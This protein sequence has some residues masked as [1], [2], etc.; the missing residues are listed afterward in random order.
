MT[1]PS[2]LKCGMERRVGGR[3]GT[4]ELCLPSCL[5]LAPPLPHFRCLSVCR[6]QGFGGQGQAC[7]PAAAQTSPATPRSGSAQG[8]GLSGPGVNLPRSVTC[9]LTYLISISLNRKSIILIFEYNFTTFY[10]KKLKD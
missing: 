8:Q 4:D 10:K 7:D 9:A 3:M 1:E 2:D 5:I 6:S